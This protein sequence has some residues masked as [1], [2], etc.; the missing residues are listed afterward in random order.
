VNRWHDFIKS[1]SKLWMFAQTFAGSGLHAIGFR[2]KAHAAERTLRSRKIEEEGE[3][4][5]QIRLSDFRF[6]RFRPN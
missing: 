2:P 4:P 1:A 6:N 5:N 3:S